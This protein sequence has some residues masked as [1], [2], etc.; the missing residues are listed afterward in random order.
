MLDL[1]FDRYRIVKKLGEGA[2]S[3]VYKA[4]DTKI[5]R[6][7]ALKVL[8][9]EFGDNKSI[10]GK[11]LTEAK[12]LSQL[13][14]PNIGVVYDVDETPDGHIYLVM[15]Y[16][17]GQT[18]E[19]RLEKGPVSID[20]A[21]NTAIEIIHGLS[22][23]HDHGIVHRD[24]KPSNILITEGGSIKILDFGLAQF[25]DSSSNSRRLHYSGTPAYVAP[26]QITHHIVEEQSDIWSLG[27]ILYEMITGVNP[28]H[29]TDINA[30]LYKIINKNPEPASKYVSDIPRTVE[31]FLQDVLH[32]NSSDRL[33]SLELITQKL[34]NVV[35]EISDSRLVA[36]NH[37][38]AHIRILPLLTFPENRELQEL[39]TRLTYSLV[40]SIK[41][42]IID[43]P[44]TDVNV[45][46]RAKRK[47]SS[48]ES[49]KTL[50]N[51]YTIDGILTQNGSKRLCHIQITHHNPKELDWQKR[52]EFHVSELSNVA[53]RVVNDIENILYQK[54]S[55]DVATHV[56]DMK[57]L[58]PDIAA[59]FQEGMQYFWQAHYQ[60]RS[61]QDLLKARR[62]F[63]KGIKLVPKFAPFHA[64]LAG[65]SFAYEFFYTKSY[66]RN[67]V[68]HC[69]NLCKKSIELDPELAE[70]YGMMAI[71]YYLLRDYS[72]MTNCITTALQ[73]N[74]H[75][76]TALNLSGWCNCLTGK[77]SH[78]IK[79]IQ[80]AF[81]Y[82]TLGIESYHY[83]CKALYYTLQ[84][85]DAIH[86]ADTG[87]QLLPNTWLFNLDLAYL[88]LFKGDYE[89]AFSLYEQY[90][91]EDQDGFHG[92]AF[93]KLGDTKKTNELIDTFIER[94]N[95]YDAAL[96]LT[97]LGETKE[98]VNMLLELLMMYPEDLNPIN[99]EH[100]EDFGTI[101]ADPRF[102]P[103]RS[104]PGYQVL[105]ERMGLPRSDA[106]S[107]TASVLQ[108]DV[109]E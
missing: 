26:E 73:I 44:Y 104:E 51:G 84:I 56:P 91:G 14:H 64:F 72:N 50:A 31:Q 32:K 94:N 107:Q 42:Q 69:I 36:N 85:D 41:G 62:I 18:L 29:S 105:R 93:A 90:S 65:S 9:Q 40:E 52:Y 97:G 24:L 34:Y 39:S 58:T 81:Y 11:I 23:A 4:H 87:S 74:P 1:S 79:K 21:L 61:Y 109:W 55:D 5:D 59:L 28:F 7:V 35:N 47:N 25:L 106:Q 8:S 46:S 13:D 54:D 75:S 6:F 27:V 16:Y 100:R 92:Y 48:L 12:A 2:A 33:K 96:T 70:S 45:G 53:N 37:D 60:T 15:R 68:E 17:D 95:L 101:H 19:A 71:Y 83:L 77:V 89:Q 38:I 30:V 20:K 86:L 78:G 103:I 57:G 76:T 88:Y 66:T 82:D 99:A 10:R 98:A 49:I 63:Q 43:Y 3:A 67:L 80:N 102:D 108:A 22:V